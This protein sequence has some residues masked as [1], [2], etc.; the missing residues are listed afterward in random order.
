MLSDRGNLKHL[1]FE[2]A[3]AR[4]RPQ[5]RDLLDWRLKAGQCRLHPTRQVT[6]GYLQLKRQ[7]QGGIF[8]HYSVSAKEL[9]SKTWLADKRG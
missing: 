3:A 5:E 6:N 9:Q 4:P 7:L 8:I 2:G 1:G